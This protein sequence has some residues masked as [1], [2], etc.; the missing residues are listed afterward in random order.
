[1]TAIPP[2]VYEAIKDW[3]CHRYGIDRTKI[4]RPFYPGGDYQA[5]DYPEGAV[6]LDN[7]PFSIISEIVRWYA[8]HDIPYFLFCPGLTAFSIGPSFDANAH[9]VFAGAQIV[10][11]N[12]AKVSTAF[13]TSYGEYLAETAPDLFRTLKEIQKR[14]DSV[15]S[16]DYPDHIVTSARMNNL[17]KYGIELSIDK[18]EAV[19]ISA[20]DEQ[21]DCGKTIFGK[22]LLLS[23]EAAERHRA[24]REKAAR[25]K[26]AREWTLSKRELEMV[27]SL[28]TPTR[29]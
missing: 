13:V 4:V 23:D 19:Y 17:A 27:A 28:A 12:G 2:Q 7:P 29:T 1:M 6:V 3:A 20:L 16:Y 11:A 22:G 5:Y 9:L 26:A 25:E 8:A 10:Y 21:R 15:A 24:A 18:G 14:P